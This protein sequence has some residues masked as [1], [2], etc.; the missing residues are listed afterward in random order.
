MKR[1]WRLLAAWIVTYVVFL[2]INLQAFAWSMMN[3]R[4]EAPLEGRLA[5]REHVGEVVSKVLTLP[6]AWLPSSTGKY[7]APVHWFV[8]PLLWTA[9][10]MTPV[11]ILLLKR[12]RKK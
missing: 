12:A 7:I 2:A 5:V 6:V 9:C 8:V 11:S 1:H 10:V 3:L 4:G